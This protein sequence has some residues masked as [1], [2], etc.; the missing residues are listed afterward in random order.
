M[1]VICL[2]FVYWVNSAYHMITGCVIVLPFW[3]GLSIY[4]IGM[5]S[6]SWPYI[7]SRNEMRINIKRLTVYDKKQSDMTII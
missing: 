2:H 4:C 7:I 1:A 3:L 6:L 5:T